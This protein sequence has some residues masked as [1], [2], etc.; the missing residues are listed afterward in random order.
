VPTERERTP[1]TPTP[2]GDLRRRHH[3][4]SIQVRSG[5][6]QLG[7]FGVNEGSFLSPQLVRV[8][9]RREPAGVWLGAPEPVAVT[10]F[11]YPHNVQL[12]PDGTVLGCG[13]ADG[14]FVAC[15]R[16]VRTGGWTRGIAIDD[17]H[18]YVGISSQSFSFAQRPNET[19]PENPAEVVRIDR[20]TLE[21]TGRFAFGKPGQI[22]DV[23]L[24][25]GPDYGLSADAEADPGARRRRLAI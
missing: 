19:V 17:R 12:R 24:A 2:T 25:A 10:G 3:I 21:V 22:Y 15:H 20:Q 1:G 16:K 7:L 5:E 9:W 4:N 11:R 18:Y 6:V 13:S 14:E 23:R 8:P